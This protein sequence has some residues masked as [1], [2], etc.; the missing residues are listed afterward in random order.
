[1]KRPKTSRARSPRAPS[2][3][4]PELMEACLAAHARG[5]FVLTLG[6]DHSVALGTVSAALA[7]RPSTKVIDRG[8]PTATRLPPVR[9][10]TRTA[11]PWR[12]C[13]LV[14]SS[15]LGAAS[16]ASSGWMMLD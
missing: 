15:E 6:G 1:M 4:G 3:T 10:A 9:P 2:A 13:K 12:S 7:A 5:N 8:T 14:Q 11:C 16:S